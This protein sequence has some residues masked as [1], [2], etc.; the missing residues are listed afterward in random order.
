MEVAD[1]VE[2]DGAAMGRLEL[3]D[4]ELVGPREGAALVAEHL[5]LEELAR[6]R[7]AVDLDE[8]PGPARGELVDRAGDELL[9]RA[10][11]ASDEHG[12]VDAS[13]LAEDLAR[14][15]HLGAAPELHLASDT[16]GHR[17]G[18][19]REHFG[20][21]AHEGVD[22]L[23]ELVEARWLVEHRLHLEGDG[24]ETAVAP[25]G[26]RDDGTGILAVKLQTLNQLCG[27]GPVVAEVDEREAEATIR[28]RLQGFVR[29]RD[30]DVLVSTNAQKAEKSELRRR[31]D[32]D[33]EGSSLSY[34]STL[35]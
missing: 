32:F 35:E 21:R 3:A 17:L 33:Q 10:G 11:L 5:A 13:C 20:L 18:C 31:V 22:R 25:G 12:D 23:L 4:L 29:G 27:V 24:A 8:G 19:E 7:G 30:R 9:A 14:F 28:E 26:D 6:H 1:L 34:R 15:Q 2:K 16:P